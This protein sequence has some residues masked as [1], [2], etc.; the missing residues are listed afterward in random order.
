M[1][2][3]SVIAAVAFL[4]ACSSNGATP[5]LG[6]GLNER[7]AMTNPRHQGIPIQR[8]L[9]HSW[10]RRPPKGSKGTIWASDLGYASVDLISYPSGTLTGQ[11]AG[12]EYPYGLCSDKKG[13]VYV[14]D[15][16]T[17]TGYEIEAGTTS[18]IDSW[19][20]GGEAI[21]CSVSN[22]GDVAF[23]NFYPGGVIVFPGGG[24]TGTNYPGPG[25]DWP[26]GYDKRGNL[27][28]ECSYAAPCSTPHLAELSGGKWT[29]LDFDTTISFPGAV[30][31]MGAVLGVAD[32]APGGETEMG[33]Y[34]TS[35]NG[36]SAHDVKTV[37]FTGVHS[38]PYIEWPASWGSLSKKPDG[39]Q[40]RKGAIKS[41]AATDANC[42][43]GV[44][45]WNAAKGGA[46]MKTFEPLSG[47]GVIGTTF[48]K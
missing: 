38:C 4:S 47:E 12:F 34:Y 28:V 43:A 13:N 40:S 33:L 41:I 22:T 45:V 31:L 32:Q 16:G 8:P 9:A 5:S 21:G 3:L 42:S 17:A 1:K 48:T 36:S 25:Y 14:A 30:Q 10:M 15:F 27:F 19:P 11:V 7:M 18:V 26:A 23:T 46:P 37:I 20:T 39:I 44:A 35:V 29:L 2:P 6:T 24:P